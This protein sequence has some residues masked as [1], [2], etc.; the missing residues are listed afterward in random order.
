MVFDNHVKKRKKCM[1]LFMAVLLM[2]SVGCGQKE[3]GE[4]DTGDQQEEEVKKLAQ[5]SDVGGTVWS[6]SWECE[7][8]YFAKINVQTDALVIVPAVEKMAVAEVKEFT[9]DKENFQMVAQGIFGSS[10][11]SYDED[12]EKLPE[13]MLK[14]KLE[15]TERELKFNGQEME[16]AEQN[17]G[18]YSDQEKNKIV[19]NVKKGREDVK[20]LTE[21]L[22]N[23]SNGEDFVLEPAG[24]YQSDHYVGEWNG[25]EYLL[26]FKEEH[27]FEYGEGVRKI[28]FTPRKEKDVWPEELKDME[29]VTKRVA[30]RKPDNEAGFEEAQKAA[31]DYLKKSGFSDTLCSDSGLLMWDGTPSEGSGQQ[32]KTV[33]KG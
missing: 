8:S 23:T 5:Y 9:F 33:Q 31:E 17:P 14:K 28:L 15:E 21:L 6:E 20:R 32:V 19:E 10:V 25:K 4:A 30:F 12:D 18:V 3:G 16:E 13:D 26:N 2:F 22:E 1:I 27:E 11:S 7:S 29:E 24:D